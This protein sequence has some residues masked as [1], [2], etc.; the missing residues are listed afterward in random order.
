[1]LPYVLLPLMFL[2]GKVHCYSNRPQL[3]SINILDMS[4][5]DVGVG[6]FPGKLQICHQDLAKMILKLMSTIKEINKKLRCVHG[7][8]TVVT[9]AIISLVIALV[10]VSKIAAVIFGYLPV[11]AVTTFVASKWKKS[12]ATLKQKK[13]VV[14]SMERATMVALKEV[15]KISRLVSRLEAVK[16]SVR[17]I[18]DF[19]VAQR[20]VG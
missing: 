4:T 18:A 3:P 6:Y 5:Y 11:E 10:T 12:T 7:R 17:V 19:V 1:M 13:T 16:R 15:E 8:R 20:N 9:A 14:S 2:N